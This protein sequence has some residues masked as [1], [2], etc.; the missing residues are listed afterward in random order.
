MPDMANRVASTA[1]RIYAIDQ[2]TGNSF[3]R[4]IYQHLVTFIEVLR[5]RRQWTALRYQLRT[6]MSA[7]IAKIADLMGV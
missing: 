7:A 1:V 2:W 5:P 4:A 6:G 3:C